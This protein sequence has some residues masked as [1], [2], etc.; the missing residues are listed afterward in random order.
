[1]PSFFVRKKFVSICKLFF[2]NALQTVD[3]VKTV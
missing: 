3:K 2:K 1:M